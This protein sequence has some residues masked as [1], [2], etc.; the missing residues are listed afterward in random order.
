MQPH[1]IL[2]SVINPPNPA[3]QHG[4]IPDAGSAYNALGELYD[5]WVHSVVDDIPFYLRIADDAR[6]AGDT[7]SPQPDQRRHRARVLELGA[8][9]GRVTRP[10]LA[11]GHHVTAVDVAEDQ[12]MRLETRAREAAVSTFLTTVHADMRTVLTDTPDGAYDAIIAPFRCL[13]HVAHDAPVIFTEARRALRP[14]GIFAFD[15]FHPPRGSEGALVATWQL[16]RR[17]MLQDGEWSIRE[18]A[19]A[20]PSG[21]ELRLY[22]RCD[23]PA[24]TRREAVMQL[25]TPSPHWWRDALETAGFAVLGVHAWFDGEPFDITASDSVWIATSA[26]EE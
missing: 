18:R 25:Q 3:S 12:L 20:D 24:G 14:G 23:G 9:S 17:V 10:L 11:A 7:S 6:P 16:R 26:H 19:T 5:E 22:V 4:E 8:G 13:L 1:G 2:R 21:E 15:V